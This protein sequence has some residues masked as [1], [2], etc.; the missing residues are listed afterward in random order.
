MNICKV[1]R[2]RTFLHCKR[3]FATQQRP[4][5]LSKDFML[6]HS[7]VAL[8]HF[9]L[10]NSIFFLLAEMQVPEWERSL[11]QPLWPENGM[12]WVGSSHGP[13]CV[14]PYPLL[15]QYLTA[16]LLAPY[17]HRCFEHLLQRSAHPCPKS[18]TE[19]K[20]SVSWLWRRGK[21]ELFLVGLVGV[22]AGYHVGHVLPVTGADKP[23]KAIGKAAKPEIQPFSGAQLWKACGIS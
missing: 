1:R 14:A 11:F 17:C 4:S 2:L 8:L 5:K 23:E 12:Q 19:A 21:I 16:V 18:E 6:L 10:V 9:V 15:L 22:G 3:V 20:S 7:H 13:H